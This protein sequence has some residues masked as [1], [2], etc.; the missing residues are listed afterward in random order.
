MSTRTEWQT[1]KA[2]AKKAN[3][4][5][6]VKFSVKADLGPLLDKYEAAKKVY[7]KLNSGDENKAW[8]KAAET[9]F[10]VAGEANKALATYAVD[11]DKL[12]ITHDAKEVIKNALGMKIGLPLRK[13][14]DEGNKLKTRI[15]KAKQ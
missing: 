1:A 8:A 2:N 13:S 3:G 11:V 4:N 14:V 15:A 10:A 6:E 7:E 12:T 9:Y 5:V